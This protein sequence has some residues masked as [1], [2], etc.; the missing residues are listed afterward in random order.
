MQSNNSNFNNYHLD[1]GYPTPERP[2]PFRRQPVMCATSG[3]HHQEAPCFQLGS[4]KNEIH[5]RMNENMIKELINSIPSEALVGSGV[6]QEIFMELREFIGLA[7]PEAIIDE[8]NPE[9]PFIV[10]RYRSGL[11]VMMTHEILHD[12]CSLLKSLEGK[13]LSSSYSLKLQSEKILFAPPP[14]YRRPNYCDHA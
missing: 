10:G 6:L 9:Q 3:P 7:K 1:G 4:F 8:K 14:N 5:L 2:A 12:L 11:F 13:L